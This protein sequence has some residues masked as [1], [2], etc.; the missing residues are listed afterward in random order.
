M[1]LLHHARGHDRE[2]RLADLG[3]QK[4]MAVERILRAGGNPDAIDRVEMAY[5][6]IFGAEHRARQRA[7]GEATPDR[8]RVV[9]RNRRIPLNRPDETDLLIPW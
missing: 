6:S 4:A 1:T 3:H 8:K 2:A 9:R 5:A 7:Q